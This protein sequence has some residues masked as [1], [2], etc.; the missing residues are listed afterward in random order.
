M[1][2][3]THECRHCGNSWSDNI[4]RGRCPECH[5]YEVV[6]LFDEQP[7][8]VDNLGPDSDAEDEKDDRED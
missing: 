4:P 1:A 3:M 5:S 2:C 6:H 8:L 7:M